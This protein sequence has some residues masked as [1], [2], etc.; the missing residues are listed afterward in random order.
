VVGDVAAITASRV[1]EAHVVDH[2]EPDVTGQDGVGGLVA[3]FLGVA[4][5]MAG[6]AE[7]PAQHRVERPLAR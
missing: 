7:E 3:E 6:Q 4:L 1:Q 2:A 5:V